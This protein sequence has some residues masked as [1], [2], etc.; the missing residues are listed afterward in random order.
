MRSIKTIKSKTIT[1]PVTN[2][3]EANS[4]LDTSS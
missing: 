3:P 4:N 1:K 2:L